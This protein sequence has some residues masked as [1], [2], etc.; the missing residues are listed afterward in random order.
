MYT[1]KHTLIFLTNSNLKPPNNF[2]LYRKSNALNKSLALEKDCINTVFYFLL[3]PTYL[4]FLENAKIASNI[5]P[6]NH[7]PK[8]NPIPFLNPSAKVN[9]V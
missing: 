6:S 9:L 4:V 3:N 5:G 8:P 7:N 1:K 2:T